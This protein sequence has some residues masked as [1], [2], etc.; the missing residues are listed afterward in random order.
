MKLP[1]AIL[2][3][4]ACLAAGPVDEFVRVSPRDPRYLELSG[5]DPYI[6]VGPNM[7]A[8]PRAADDEESFRIFES[9]LEKLA[10]NGGNYIRVWLSNSNWDV[11][12]ERSGIYD[13]GRARRIDRMLAACRK[14][15]IRV[16]L[17]MEHFRTIGEPAT[18]KWAD[19][20]MHR[21]D[22]GGP[23]KSIAD[24]FDGPAPR[25]Q[26][27]KKIRWYADRYHDQPIVFA[28]EL[29]NEINAV[30]G[31]DYL[32]W[33]EAMLPEL[34]KAF[35]KN[36]AVQ[37]LGSFDRTRARDAYR[38]HSLMPANDLAQ[39][40]RYL[41][42]GAE[43]DVCRGPV[44]VLAADAVRELIGYGV[45]K[46]VLLA[47]SGAVEPKHS[48]PFQLYK[49]DRAGVILHDV[50][51]APFFAGAAGAGQIWHWDAYV[52]ANDLWWQFGR[53]AEA[54]KGIDPPAEKFEPSMIDHDRLRVYV[55]KGRNT[56][57]AWCR[58]KRNTWES[59]LKNGE[60]P[61]KLRDI[62]VYFGDASGRARVYDPWSGQ[63][64]EAVLKEGRLK[65]PE[66]SRS[67]V[68]RI[69]SGA[70]VWWELKNLKRHFEASD[71]PVGH[72]FGP[73]PKRPE[74]AFLA[75]KSA[76][77][78]RSLVELVSG[79][80][81]AFDAGGTAPR[82]IRPAGTKT[83]EVDS[84]DLAGTR[85]GDWVVLFNVEQLSTRSAVWF[86]VKGGA[87]LRFL[88]TGLAPGTWEIWR[89]GFLED[90]GGVV[91]RGAGALYFEGEAGQYFL[92]RL[93]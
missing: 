24:F 35:P 59:E 46:P 73:D 28:W 45:R 41:D 15:G 57:L 82:L 34:H 63:W 69:E 4:A 43:L 9:W 37:S 72:D 17:T 31:G 30:R 47:E 65:L 6:P 79:A 32:A 38:R 22:N 21:A 75:V 56:T 36:L 16:K 26:F 12:H 3:L 60:R 58:D 76:R 61:E 84:L 70:A 71:T 14:H 74:Y 39:V 92:R 44:D 81:L 5:G 78:I 90:P 20:P 7:I 18:Q 67:L 88:V 10:A 52:A 11:E 51:F 53:F 77:G 86:E 64:S 87:R 91:W 42:L 49:T 93:S 8:P 66:F 48:G 50:L 89:N 54:V 83:G 23:A 2:L 13:A 1:A 62:E 33:T 80:L 19:K 55:L 68:V 85:L 25:E 29:W 40:H 27:R